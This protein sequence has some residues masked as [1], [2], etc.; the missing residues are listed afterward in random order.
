MLRLSNE[1][2]RRQKGVEFLGEN[3]NCK[4][5]EK[6]LGIT[7]VNL[8]VIDSNLPGYLFGLARPAG[9]VALISSHRLHSY[10]PGESHPSLLV[11]RMTKEAMH[12]LGHLFD[13]TH[14]H[15]KT[16]VMFG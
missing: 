13:L 9:K 14:C 4:A 12:E 11:E 16:C 3:H 15:N 2:V 7:D 6:I 5:S 10:P 1:G 8:C